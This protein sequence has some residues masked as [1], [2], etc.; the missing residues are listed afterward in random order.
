MKKE[1]ININI[2]ILKTLREI[3]EFLNF[4]PIFLGVL[5]VCIILAMM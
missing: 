4:L 5:T 2:E 1:L 3:K